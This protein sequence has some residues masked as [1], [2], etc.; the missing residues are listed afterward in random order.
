[1]P[2]P[3]SVAAEKLP[4]SE[5]DRKI[6]APCTALVPFVTRIIKTISPPGVM[7]VGVGAAATVKGGNG[8]KIIKVCADPL[9]KPFSL[10]TT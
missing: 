8:V 3:P 10:A 9:R 6:V 7:D 5:E 4:P 1:M 2:F